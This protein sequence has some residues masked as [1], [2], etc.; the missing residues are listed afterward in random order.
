MSNIDKE[1]NDM[2]NYTSGLTEYVNKLRERA[3]NTMLDYFAE[4][5]QFPK[6]VIEEQKIFYIGDT[7]E[8]LLPSFYDKVE[9]YGVISPTNKKPIFHNRFVMPIM[10]T[11]G[12]VLNLVG[13]SKEANERYVYGTAKY[14]R[15]RETM[16]GLE[17]LNMA[18][19]LGYA[20]VT[21][22][23]TDTIRLRGLGYKNTFAMCGTHKSEFIMKQ[24]NRCRYGVI[25]IPDRDEAGQKA[26]RGWYCNRSIMLNTFIAYKDID[27]MCSASEENI[28]WVKDYIDDC[29]NWIKQKEH[30]GLNCGMEVVTMC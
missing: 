17:N 13:Y 30:M 1:L 25:K 26:A 23:I 2:K 18:Y 8:M 19:E 7:T 21:E 5:R 24:L 12:N 10:D 29:I 20:L 28:P 16:Y 15:R 27:E 11:N 3:G 6:E 22:G 14:Y 4:L 9:E